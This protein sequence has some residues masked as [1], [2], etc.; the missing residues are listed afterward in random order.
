MLD[1]GSSS[2]SDFDELE[3]VWEAVG[4]Q[5]GGSSRRPLL[6]AVMSQGCRCALPLRPSHSSAVDSLS[7]CRV[8]IM[9]CQST[10]LAAGLPLGALAPQRAA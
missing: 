1:D 6:V 2:G 9:M 5:V 3:E 10:P 8:R 7:A 4:G